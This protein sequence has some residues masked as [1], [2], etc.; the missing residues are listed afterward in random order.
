MADTHTIGIYSKQFKMAF[1]KYYEGA[2][3]GKKRKL[4]PSERSEKKIKSKKKKQAR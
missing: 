2:L 3:P 4:T 1:L